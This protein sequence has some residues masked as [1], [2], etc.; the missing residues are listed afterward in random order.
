MPEAVEGRAPQHGHAEVG[1]VGEPH[2]VVVAGEDGLAD[3]EADLG[4]VD[5]ERGDDLDVADVVAAEDDVH[6]AGHGLVGVG[7][8]VVLEALH[9]RAGAV[10]DAGDGETDGPE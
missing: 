4:G 6:E 1:H 5:V 3:V 8:L 2:R 9:Q 10:P 7:V